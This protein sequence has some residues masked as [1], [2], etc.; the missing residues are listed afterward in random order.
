M[1]QTTEET[2]Q[3]ELSI[4]EFRSIMR[5]AFRREALLKQFGLLSDNAR[6]FAAQLGE[7]SGKTCSDRDICIPTPAYTRMDG[8]H[9]DTQWL[10]YLIGG[11]EHLAETRKLPAEELRSLIAGT[12]YISNLDIS[13][14]DTRLIFAEVGK[15]MARNDCD[16]HG[17]REAGT[18]HMAWWLS[19]LDEKPEPSTLEHAT[20]ARPKD[21]Q[22]Y[23]PMSYLDIC[24]VLRP[25]QPLH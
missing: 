24:I 9:L 7:W 6:R 19:T 1:N 25:K 4:N 10:L 21:R 16:A 14:K 11:A 8:S 18:E 15:L 12:W 5:R 2:V 22:P 20:L 23:E 13:L 3:G 17:L